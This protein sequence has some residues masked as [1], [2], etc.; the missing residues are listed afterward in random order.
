MSNN[1]SK[2]AKD[3]VVIVAASRTPIGGF[4]GA[5]QSQTA[6]Q[7]GAVAI[8]DALKRCELKGEAWTK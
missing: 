3:P 2:N 7:L 5:L 6:T 1:P 4:L 8:A